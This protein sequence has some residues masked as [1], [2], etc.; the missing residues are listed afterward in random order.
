[1]VLF[2]II[3]ILFIL[4]SLLMLYY[5]QAWQS[6]PVFQTK[7][8]QSTLKISVIV[9]ARNEEKNIGQLLMALQNQT[10]PTSLFEVII[11]DDHST[12]STV[13][14]VQQFDFVQL[15]SLQ[16][17]TLI[18]YKKKAIEKG[19]AMASGEFIVT[20]DADCIPGKDWLATLASFQSST[21]SVCI[22]APVVY[23]SRSSFLS[24]F[25]TLDFMTLQGITAVAVAKNLFSMSNGANFGYSQK[26][27]EAVNGFSGIDTIASGDDV[28]LLQKIR[29][30]FPTKVRYLKS[31][32][33]IVKT[34][35]MPD[36]K[37]F[38]AQRKRWA[39]KTKFYTEQKIKINLW[40]VFLLHLS[41]LAAIVYSFFHPKYGLLLLAFWLGKTIIEFPFVYQ[42]AKF[43]KKLSLIKYFFL[44]QPVHFFYTIYIGIASQ[45][46]NYEWKGRKLK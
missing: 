41:I 22:V 7:N 4:Y 12:D 46:G 24:V 30:Q 5:W 29:Q 32:D 39:G 34:E 36:L 26:V 25:Q 43:F 14:I 38:I 45:L 37:T 33:A 1:M 8:K 20:T 15:I 18:A 9:A 27:F 6:I 21:D 42:L 3:I 23:E 13:A 19:I 35:P 28:L 10:Y 44:L 2:Y 40:L 31:A 11:I 17:D 16:D